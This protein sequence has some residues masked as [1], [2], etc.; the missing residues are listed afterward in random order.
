VRWPKSLTNNLCLTI[1]C[2]CINIDYN[3]KKHLFYLF[4]LFIIPKNV[5]T[6][7]VERKSLLMK[8]GYSKFVKE[9]ETLVVFQE[10]LQFRNLP[11]TE[12]WCCYR[13]TMKHSYINI[14]RPH[15][16]ITFLN[17]C[18]YVHESYTVMNSREWI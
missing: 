3:T 6:K 16:L 12:H 8:I 17:F 13:L 4:Y 11:R 2:K 9:K 14:Y 15:Y 1:R 18:A 5:W 10:D 7:S